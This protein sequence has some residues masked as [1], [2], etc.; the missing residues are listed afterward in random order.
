MFIGD[1]LATDGELAK[2][3]WQFGLVF[4]GNTSEAQ[5]ESLVDQEW[6]SESFRCARTTS[7]WAPTRRDRSSQRRRLD[8]ELVGEGLR[9]RKRLLNSWWLLVE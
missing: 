5:A 7:R 1:S 3:G 4:S 8:A 2:T 6:V 9:Q